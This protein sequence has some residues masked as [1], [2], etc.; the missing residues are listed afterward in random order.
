MR[1]LISLAIIFSMTIFTFGAYALDDEFNDN[2]FNTVD[3]WSLYFG[4]PAPVEDGET[5]VC[6]GSN[7]GSVQMFEP[8]AIISFLGVSI[9]ATDNSPDNYLGLF[10]NIATAWV[11]E[12][13]MFMFFQSRVHCVVRD[14][15]SEGDVIVDLGPIADV[16]GL[17][18]P[19]DYQIDWIDDNVIKFYIDGVEVAEIVME[20]D[21][22]G[23]LPVFVRT[24][25]AMVY[26][27]DYISDDFDPVFPVI[28][29]EESDGSTVLT[30]ADVAATDS[31]T[32][33]LGSEPTENVMVEVV[34][35]SEQV[36]LLS[37]PQLQF[38]PENYD[39]PQT[40][41]VEVVD[42]LVKEGLTVDI[43]HF[44]TISHTVTGSGLDTK[45]TP[46]VEVTI[47]DNDLGSSSVASKRTMVIDGFLEEWVLLDSDTLRV[48]F[49]GREVD[50]R[51][52]WDEDNL[53]VAVEEVVVDPTPTEGTDH[54]DWFNLTPENTDSIGF[55]DA[56]G[57]LPGPGPNG[58][59]GPFTQFFTGLSSDGNPGR[60]MV[61]TTADDPSTNTLVTEAGRQG[62]N[63]TSDGR[64]ITEFSM[65]WADIRFSELLTDVKEG[66]TFRLDPLLVD[67]AAGGSSQSFP[68]G[69]TM[70]G[71]VTMNNVNFIVLGPE[72]PGTLYNAEMAIITVD[73]NL[74]D[75]TNLNSGTLN[76]ISENNDTS[77]DGTREHDIR[78]AWDADNLYVSVEEKV[79][80]NF[81]AEGIGHTDWFTFLKPWGT[82]SV[83][84]Y[85]APTIGGAP[86]GPGP[87]GENGATGPVVQFWVGMA[88]DGDPGRHQAR[89]VPESDMNDFLIVGQ[90]AVS[91]TNE[92]HRISEFFM[93]WEDIKFPREYP[94]KGAD[95]YSFVKAGYTF[96]LDPLM[97]DGVEETPGAFH[98]QSFPGGKDRPGDVEREDM[99][100]VRLIDVQVPDFVFIRADA[101]LDG[102]VNLPDMQ[103][104]LNFLFLGGPDPKCMASADSNGDGNINLP[105][106]QFG[107]N[108]LFL[109]GNNPQDPFDVCGPV[110]R[111]NDISLGCENS[112]DLGCLDSL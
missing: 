10:D 93:P 8:G 50:V 111:E 107:L 80:D 23:P 92:G 27:I 78:F 15:E 42:D 54:S 35:D 109:G 94:E 62:V 2:S 63:L 49:N 1:K 69:S 44:T 17:N 101:N 74:D 11:D 18:V 83:G 81:F 52:A 86:V 41:I 28:N 85:D 36:R 14:L 32:V 91:I 102:N 77:K 75:W 108:F 53:Y 7:F 97:V 29:I 51:Y 72:P 33:A 95:D 19:H 55:F 59:T 96:R 22:T 66:Y 100:F 73:G 71:D 5:I 37:D 45:L 46:S 43:P 3:T 12:R 70:A 103:F 79:V 4:A 76:Q 48:V 68:D 104:I 24:M 56:P 13:I 38:T 9:L 87:I 25:D 60:L 90:N 88:S 39:M 112:L 34:F 110:T 82:D 98:G 16:V 31:Y 57:P 58:E 47:T 6:E 30:E 40:V 61:R 26:E 84:F 67:G 20:Q 21:I 99:S 65:P 106:A 89:S 64:R 105:D